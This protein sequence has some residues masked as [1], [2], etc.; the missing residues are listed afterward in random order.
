[1]L[2][3]QFNITT[4]DVTAT[5]WP[6]PKVELPAGI[7]QINVPDGTVFDNMMVDVTTLQLVPVP[8]SS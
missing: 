1:M 3:I 2:G 4:G 6:A 5:V 7:G 8:P